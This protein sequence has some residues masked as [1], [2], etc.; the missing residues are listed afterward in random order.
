VIKIEIYE[1]IEKA[2]KREVESVVGHKTRKRESVDI[3]QCDYTPEVQE[4]ERR[5]ALKGAKA[6]ELS[7]CGYTS[8][9]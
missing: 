6:I 7:V 2:R 4:T 1:I 5:A 9:T 3:G 8:L